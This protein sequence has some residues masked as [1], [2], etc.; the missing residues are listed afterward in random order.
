MAQNG[1]FRNIG[2]KL[3]VLKVRDYDV[4]ITNLAGAGSTATGTIS[5]DPDSPF[6]LRRI[7]ASDTNDPTIAAPGVEGQYEPLIQ[8]QDN[9]NNYTWQN[10]P[11][12][13][14]QVAGTREYPREL[15]DEV[16]INANT[17][18]TISIQQPA[19]GAA[20]G[21]TTFAL[22]GYSLYLVPKDSGQ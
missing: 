8:V 1:A 14:S 6:L 9:S 18:F 5:I 22:C 19:A 20:A 10:Q 12:P 15:E 7:Y 3:Y 2:S 4:N 21:T 17:R 13:R 16:L 11:A